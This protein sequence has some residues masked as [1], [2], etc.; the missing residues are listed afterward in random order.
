[1]SA[2]ST[3]R[4]CQFCKIHEPRPGD[5]FCAP[6]TGRACAR[7]HLGIVLTD[8]EAMLINMRNDPVG[9]SQFGSIF[10]ENFK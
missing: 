2:N 6:V 1:M 7:L 9:M 8:K 4:R 5:N 3:I 10:G